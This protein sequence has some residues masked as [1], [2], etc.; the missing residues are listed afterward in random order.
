MYVD[1][2]RNY[3]AFITPPR[4]HYNINRQEIC[5]YA[6][7]LINMILINLTSYRI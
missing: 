4:F 5:Q 1:L 2:S 3:K 7:E 6:F